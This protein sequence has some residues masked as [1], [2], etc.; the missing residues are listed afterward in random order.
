MSYTHFLSKCKGI[1][2]T[3]QNSYELTGDLVIP[4]NFH[5]EI[6]MTSTAGTI[7]HVVGFEPSV[8]YQS[9]ISASSS[10]II[11]QVQGKK[12]TNRIAAS[13]CKFLEDYT[14]ST[15]WVRTVNTIPKVIV[16]P[17]INKY[18]QEM[19]KGDWAIGAAPGKSLKIGRITRW[20]NNNIWGTMSDNLDDKHRDFKFESIHEI[21]I[22][23]HDPSALLTFATLKGWNGY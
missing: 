11:F 1:E 13:Y 21:F 17:P 22:L 20:T 14:G 18:K 5:I 16:K 2:K 12:G 8:Y 6:Y 23:D 10:T 15:K 4:T 19:K 9:I 7:G 3:Q